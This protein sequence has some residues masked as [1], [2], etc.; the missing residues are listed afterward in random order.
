MSHPSIFSDSKYAFNRKDL[1][2]DE[3]MAHVAADPTIP[4]QWRDKATALLRDLDSWPPPPRPPARPTLTIRLQFDRELWM[5]FYLVAKFSD[6][7][8]DD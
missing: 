4:K 3:F 2:P 8:R 6:D 1:R 7:S 5:H